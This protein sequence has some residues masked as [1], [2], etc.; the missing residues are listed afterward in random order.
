MKM[1]FRL[2]LKFLCLYLIVLGVCAVGSALG[3]R[4]CVIGMSVLSRV[5]VVAW[6]AVVAPEDHG[7]SDLSTRK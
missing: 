1:I 2:I 5:A 3:S 7:Q 4:T 6:E